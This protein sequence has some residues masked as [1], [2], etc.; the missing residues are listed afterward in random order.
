MKKLLLSA[1]LMLGTSTLAFAE[2]KTINGCD[3]QKAANGNYYSKVNPGCVGT[4][5]AFIKPETAYGTDGIARDAAE[6]EAP[7][8]PGDAEPKA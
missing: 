5:G 8:D 7:S 3:V 4:L 1:A 6:S 2:T